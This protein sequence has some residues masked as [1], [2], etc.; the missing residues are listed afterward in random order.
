MLEDMCGRF[1][2][3]RASSELIGVFD[4]EVTG[5]QLPKPSWNIAPTQAIHVVIDSIP[6]TGDMPEPVRRLESARWGL[7]PGWTK[8]YPSGAPLF[9]ARSETVAEKVA[10]SG[11]L[12]KR[13]AIIPASGYY[14][15]QVID[16]VK[17]PHYISL[18][19]DELLVFAGL[20][21]WWRNP[22]VDSGTN[23]MWLLSSTI[24]TTASTGGLADLHERMPVFLDADLVDEWLDPHTDGDDDLV[25]LVVSG[26][27]EVAQ[28]ATFHRVGDEVGV[29]Q[30]NSP[31]LVV[32]A[33]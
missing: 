3:D 10:F 1:V 22:G 17:V 21:E 26:A 28:R 7:V 12:E 31:E 19:G 5:N 20:Y 32:P 30:N 23:G 4:I 11:A 15:W 16:G 2:L 18:P 33:V 6:R 8:E 27:S 24:L 9:N 13:R 25:Q 29:V 14:E